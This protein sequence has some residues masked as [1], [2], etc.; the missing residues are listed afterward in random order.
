MS[1][2][3]VSL[4]VSCLLLDFGRISVGTFV[5]AVRAADGPAAFGVGGGGATGA[6]GL[7]CNTWVRSGRFRKA[8]SCFGFHFGILILRDR[9]ILLADDIQ[10]LPEDITLMSLACFLFLLIFLSPVFFLIRSCLCLLIFCSIVFSLIFFGLRSIYCFKSVSLSALVPIIAMSE[11]GTRTSCLFCS[12]MTLVVGLTLQTLLP[13][14]STSCCLLGSL[15]WMK[16]SF[17]A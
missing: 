14:A 1:E 11:F 2:S 12:F 7:K 10:D 5:E 3:D 17:R 4:R 9:A 13:G 16:Y 8:S 6:G 15:Y